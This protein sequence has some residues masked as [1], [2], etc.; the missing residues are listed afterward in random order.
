LVFDNCEHFACWCVAAR[1]ES[2]QV[3]MA[4]ERLTAAGL[5]AIAAGATR[6]TSKLGVKRLIAASP[7]ILLADAAQWITEATGHRLGLRDPR[8]CK[9]AGRAVGVTTALGVGAFAGP[10]GAAVSGGLWLAAELAGQLSHAT[11]EQVR[12][13]RR[14]QHVSRSEP[15]TSKSA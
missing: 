1:D 4:C 7:W 12:E 10:A 3:S 15:S 2:R 14:Q 5:K 8:H 6:V 9:Q 13:R 11:Y